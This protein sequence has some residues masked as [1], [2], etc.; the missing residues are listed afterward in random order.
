[1]KWYITETQLCRIR[2]I[3]E[4]DKKSYIIYRTGLL[5]LSV[6]EKILAWKLGNVCMRIEKE[7]YIFFITPIDSK[8]IKSKIQ[9]TH[10]LNVSIKHT[11]TQNY[12]NT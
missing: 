8:T 12:T 11:Q 10:I 3:R 9:D 1:M 4:T 7:I 5:G 2:P 6:T